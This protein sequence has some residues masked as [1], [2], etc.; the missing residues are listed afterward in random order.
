MGLKLLEL[1]FNTTLL[2]NKAHEDESSVSTFP[3]RLGLLPRSLFSI[4]WNLT[5]VRWQTLLW[6]LV[7]VP[8]L[9]CSRVAPDGNSIKRPWWGR[10]LCEMWN[11]ALMNYVWLHP[12]PPRPSRPPSGTARFFEAL[13]EHCSLARH[14]GGSAGALG[15]TSPRTFCGA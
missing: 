9:S 4:Y 15:R 5:K 7:F 13:P 14:T 12:R 6:R 2:H 3:K 1:H 8:E 10:G 11:P